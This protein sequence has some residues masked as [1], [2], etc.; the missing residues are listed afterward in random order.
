MQDKSLYFYKKRKVFGVKMK[1]VGVV[2]EFNP[3]HKG[4]EYLLSCLR[5]GGAELVICVMSG[6]FVQ[7]G[8]PAF[9]DKYTRGAMAIEC[10]ADIVLELPYPYSAAGAEY[11]AS[12]AVKI[13]A[14][15]GVDTLGFGS[16][17]GDVE[18]LKNAAERVS[19]KRF[20]EEYK[21]LCRE[22]S[23]GAAA[24]FKAYNELYGEE[25]PGGSNDILGIEYIKAAKS[26]GADLSFE[27]VTRKGAAYTSCELPENAFASASALRGK[28]LDDRALDACLDYIPE[29]AIKHLEVAAEEGMAFADIRNIERAILAALRLSTPESRVDIA[30]MTDGLGSRL[31][32]F[33]L[34]ATSIDELVSF[35]SAKN[36][37]DTRIRRAML[38]YMTGVKK[39]DL[40]AAPTYSTLLAA[41]RRGLDYLS[42]KRRDLTI[43]IISKPADGKK[44]GRQFE[45]SARADAL[46]TLALLNPNSAD[47]LVKK[48][49]IIFK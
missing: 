38:F 15:A 44:L 21:R 13:L 36:Y 30:E 27:T 4:H 26:H 35:V 12:A 28:M 7:R 16:E 2:S 23:G 48:S 5:E 40:K 47:I 8:E 18:R 22:G 11:F 45:L 17:C 29:A 39:S 32:K 46:W 41:N 3:F 37:T 49:P 20:S 9:A 31:A 6:D 25:C 10:G 19:D 43:P 14:A 24:Y 33:A 34:E 1:I 42:K